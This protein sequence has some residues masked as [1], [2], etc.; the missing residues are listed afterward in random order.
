ML[1]PAGSEEV[2][3]MLGGAAA[4]TALTKLHRSFV[5]MPKRDAEIAYASSARAVRRL[6]E[7]HGA[8][9]SSGCSRISRERAL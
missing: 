1:E 4:P 5:D 2:E 3:A 7:Q 8:P 6:I 9:A